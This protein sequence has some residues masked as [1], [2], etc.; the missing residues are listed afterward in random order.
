MLPSTA[1]PAQMDGSR[2]GG[3]CLHRPHRAGRAG[4]S[5][6]GKSAMLERLEQYGFY[7]LLVG[8]ALAA[9][10][11]LWLVIAAFRTRARWG[12]A[13]LLFPPSALVFI[14]SHSRRAAGP[15]FLFLVSGL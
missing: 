10:G 1:R 11:Y 3:A 6:P 8:A 2:A 9:I 15:F 7:A 12:V 5:A 4:G 13:L 14:L